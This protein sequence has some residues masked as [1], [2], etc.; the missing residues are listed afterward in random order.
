MRALGRHT[1]CLLIGS[2]EVQG[3]RWSRLGVSCRAQEVVAEVCGGGYYWWQDPISLEA[4]LLVSSSAWT[5]KSRK[6][7][8]R[9]QGKNESSSWDGL[10]A[11]CMT[12]VLMDPSAQRFDSLAD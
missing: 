10:Y 4:E 6:A 9:T 8:L 12:L 7:S 3:W 2:W 5:S 11:R 1:T